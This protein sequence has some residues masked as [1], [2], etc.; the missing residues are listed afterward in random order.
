MR[1]DASSSL[2]WAAA[3]AASA[4]AGLATYS[5]VHID[6]DAM[7]TLTPTQ[8]QQRLAAGTA[9][10]PAPPSETAEPVLPPKGENAPS[11]RPIGGPENEVGQDKKDKDDDS[12]KDED[13]DDGRDPEPVT[14]T[15]T[16]SGGSLTV[17]C[18]GDTAFLTRWAAA[19]SFR[20]EAV[21]RGPADRV[22]VR[23]D[24]VA[25]GHDPDVIVV[26]DC[27]DG[28]PRASEFFVPDG[29]VPHDDRKRGKGK[30]GGP[31]GPGGK[32]GF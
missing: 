24:E 30:G 21:W 14:R 6:A 15:F 9:P 27:Q 16:S 28:R 2:L 19:F 3:F 26:A 17:T 13:A 12:D 20:T 8:I 4:V 29:P 11:P 7:S 23:F 18:V 5:Y 32:G 31:G 1:P 25:L 10:Q 22:G